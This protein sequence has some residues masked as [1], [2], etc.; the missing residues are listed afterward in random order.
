MIEAACPVVIFV[1]ET[2]NVNPIVR[3]INDE[4]IKVAIW[5]INNLGVCIPPCIFCCAKLFC[6]LISNDISIE[7]S[8]ESLAFHCHEIFYRSRAQAFKLLGIGF[9]LGNHALVGKNLLCL[10]L[11]EVNETVLQTGKGNLVLRE[12]ALCLIK[13]LTSAEVSV[14]KGDETIVVKVCSCLVVSLLS[15]KQRNLCAEQSLFELN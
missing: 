3:N 11:L 7:H 1:N 4:R 6:A 10:G 12:L 15:L 14:C 8:R 13:S 5:I 9:D 2:I